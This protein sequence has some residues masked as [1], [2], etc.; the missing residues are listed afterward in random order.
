MDR[1]GGESWIEKEEAGRR[2]KWDR[3]G[4]KRERGERGIEKNDKEG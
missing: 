1:E 2:S 4:G 3:E